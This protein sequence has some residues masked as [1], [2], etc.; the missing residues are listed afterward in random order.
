MYMEPGCIE[1]GSTMWGS[2]ESRPTALRQ[3]GVLL[4]DPGMQ[5]LPNEH[6]MRVNVMV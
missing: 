5:S 6:S 1:H 3:Q 2:Q 4:Y